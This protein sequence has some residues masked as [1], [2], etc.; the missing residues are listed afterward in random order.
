MQTLEYMYFLFWPFLYFLFEYECENLYSA[1]IPC[2]TVRLPGLTP[3]SP[4]IHFSVYL[5]ID[6]SKSTKCTKFL[7]MVVMAETCILAYYRQQSTNQRTNFIPEQLRHCPEKNH[8][9]S[10]DIT[11]VNTL[12]RIGTLINTWSKELIKLDSKQ[13]PRKMSYKGLIGS[14]YPSTAILSS[15]NQTFPFANHQGWNQNAPALSIDQMLILIY[16]FDKF[17][18]T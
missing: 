18:Q 12:I 8:T 5:L 1:S 15:R 10:R 13:S 4:S 9:F 16:I 3:P 14:L 6:S 11:I 7:A 2:T 17:T